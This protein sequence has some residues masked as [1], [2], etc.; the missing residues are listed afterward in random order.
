[1]LLA[2]GLAVAMVGS[3]AR[4]D[5]DDKLYACHKLPADSKLTI[6]MKPGTTLADLAVWASGFTCK[7]IVFTDG[8]AAERVTIVAPA[9]LT[10]K[11]AWELFTQTLAAY[12]L[13]AVEK[14]DTVTIREK[15]G[16]H[17]CTGIT[18]APTPPPV[19][20]VPHPPIEAQAPPIEP[21]VLDPVIANGIHKIDDEH[22]TITEAAR[23]RITED[24]FT[25]HLRQ[26]RVVPSIKDGK[27]NGFKL[28]AI[29]PDSVIARLGFQNGDTIQALNAM[30]MDTP[31]MVL[32]TWESEKHARM[33]RV[34]G[35][36]RGRPF[37]LEITTIP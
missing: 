11:K 27:P 25:D 16:T 5:E 31:D 22:V 19:E 10:P 13:V 28:Y 18:A 24:S 4:A 23:K 9:P 3:A 30:R 34:T 12:D 32:T 21:Y 1:M 7:T 14:G 17:R 35:E 29:T 36:R 26:A 6:T 8:A 33:W 2:A 20:P 15:P 37:A